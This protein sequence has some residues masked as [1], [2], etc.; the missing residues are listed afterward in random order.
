V[1]EEVISL[2]PAQ[3]II[4]ITNYMEQSISKK[5]I[6]KKCIR[7]GKKFE[8]YLFRVTKGG[9]KYCSQKCH[10]GKPKVKKRCIV[11]GKK[12]RVKNSRKDTAK[13]CSKVCRHN[14]LTVEIKCKQCGKKFQVNNYRKNKTK[15]CSMKC[16]GKSLEGK[17]GEVIKKICLICKKEFYVT[18][19]KGDKK[20]CSRKCD[21]IHRKRQF[22]KLGFLNSPETRKK[23]SIAHKGK[24]WG[25]HTEKSK[26]KMSKA[27]KGKKLSDE[28]KKQMSLFLKG[29]HLS[30]RTEFKKGQM[31]GS[32]NPAWRGGVTKLKTLLC[33]TAE[34][35]NWKL[36]ICDRDNYTCQ[37]PNCDKSEKL[38]DAHHV[39]QYAIIVNKNNIKTLEQAL[40]CKELWDIN[41]GIILCKK[42]HRVT[43][44]QEEK[45]VQLFQEIIKLKQ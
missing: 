31:N 6:E 19:S 29:K 40:S 39:I 42:C 22:Q 14:D 27:K 1:E 20:Y 17:R 32:N 37:M 43:Y 38:L 23:I 13:Y 44:N 36:N 18:P 11:C 3:Y 35:R 16:F 26:R 41:N 30:I 9:G 8:V 4:K 15:F 2:P 33:K 24:S 10:Y 34:F 45:F 5:I 28:Q 7:C 21:V 12:F 25:K